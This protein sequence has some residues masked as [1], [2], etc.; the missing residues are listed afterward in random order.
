MNQM[1]KDGKN[2]C[3]KSI[4]YLKRFIEDRK[5]GDKPSE[6]EVTRAVL[7]AFILYICDSKYV[8]LTNRDLSK[9]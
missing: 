5:G 6:D 9:K 4:K 1:K 8:K 2:P 7:N 3:K